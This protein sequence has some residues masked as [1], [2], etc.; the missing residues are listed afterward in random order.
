MHLL[1]AP[2]PR[3][4]RNSALSTSSGEPRDPAPNHP[5]SVLQS[6]AFSHP[7]AAP[8]SPQGAPG[9]GPQPLSPAH[10]TCSRLRMSC[11][12]V[13]TSSSLPPS[14]SPSVP[15]PLAAAIPP[16]PPANSYGPLRM[17]DPPHRAGA[18]PCPG[19]PHCAGARHRLASSLHCAGAPPQEN[20]GGAEV[21][22]N[23]TA[24]CGQEPW[25]T[26]KNQSYISSGQN[27]C[28]L[29]TDLEAA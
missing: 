21:E 17:R 13:S 7:P 19:E 29:G 25:K 1:Y 15:S 16:Q 10:T 3:K 18:S 12:G 22:R 11:A 8:I 26:A 6:P 2:V 24:A 5:P 28:G 27:G 9:P 14:E 20:G 23:S 4:A